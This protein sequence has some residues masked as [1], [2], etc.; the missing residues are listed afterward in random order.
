MGVTLYEEVRAALREADFRARKRLG[1]NFLVHE[2]VIEAILRLLDPAP[3]EKVLEIGPGLGV[4]TRRLLERC[5]G[6]WAVEVDPFLAQRLRKS[7]LGSD[8]KLRLIEGDILTVP[9]E[10]ILPAQKIALVGNLPYSITTPVF[11]RILEASGH[12]S[13][14]VLMVQKE[15]ADRL[16]ARPGSKQ[17]GI[18]SV[19]CRVYGKITEKVGVSPEAFFP[20]PKVRSTVL[21]IEMF[22][23][24]LA[25]A[26]E[27]SVLRALLRAAFG[28]RRKMVGNAFAAGLKRDRVELEHFLR[29]QNVDPRRRG[30]T[31]TVGEFVQLARAAREQ[32]WLGSPL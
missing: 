12:F 1:Q 2:G 5:A 26:A 30:E 29:A 3:G 14:L 28:Q 15:V 13:R 17:Y 27:I 23:E 18:L 6:V 4:L 20:R 21:K 25:T 31:L 24:P 32:S 22:S 7:A 10:E 19:W 16:A 9:L 8:P 11:F